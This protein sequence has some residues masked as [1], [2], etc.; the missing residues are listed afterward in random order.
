[1]A[2]VVGTKY[3]L[4]K[5]ADYMNICIVINGALDNP[6]ALETIEIQ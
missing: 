2:S 6:F 1:M 3:N 5:K 4:K